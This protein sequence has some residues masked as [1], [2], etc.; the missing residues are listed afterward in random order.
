MELLTDSMAATVRI[1]SE[2]LY[3]GECVTWARAD[4][5]GTVGSRLPITK[6][7][8]AGSMPVPKN[9]CAQ[10]RQP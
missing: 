5:V 8:G 2:Q 10:E 4:G 6:E 1:S 7:A 3:L 9:R